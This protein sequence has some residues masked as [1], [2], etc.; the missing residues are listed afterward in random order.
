MSREGVVTHL[1][2]IICVCLFMYLR[3]FLSTAWMGEEKEKNAPNLLKAIERFN[4]VS[5]LLIVD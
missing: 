1:V 4:L 5:V 2:L 3:E